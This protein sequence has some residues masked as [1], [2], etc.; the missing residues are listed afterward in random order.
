MDIQP[1]PGLRLLAEYDRVL[2][3]NLVRM[4]ENAID[5][6][7]LPFLHRGSFVAMRG[8]SQRSDGWSAWLKLA[9]GVLGLW[10][11]VDLSCSEPDARRVAWTTRVLEGFSSGL[12]VATEATPVHDDAIRVQVRF[13][14]PWSGVKARIMG[15]V[16]KKTYARLYDEDEAMMIARQEVVDGA[17]D[18]L[19]CPH[20][21]ASLEGL[22][23][24]DGRVECPWH[25]WQVDASTGRCLARAS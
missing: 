10:Q 1:T 11:R 22:P 3:T 7:H 17:I 6:E 4:R 8:Y 9:P 15:P 12:E 21:G 25:G 14:A 2:A 13:L 23:V 5:G 24:R 20:Q 18:G 19:R 16:L